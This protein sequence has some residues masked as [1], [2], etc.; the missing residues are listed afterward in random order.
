MSETKEMAMRSDY[1]HHVSRESVMPLNGWLTPWV[2]ELGANP[3][4]A[5]TPIIRG[6]ARR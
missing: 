1:D 3:P 6:G 5:A 2:R 4:C